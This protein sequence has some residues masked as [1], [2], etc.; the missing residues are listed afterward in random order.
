LLDKVFTNVLAD[1]YSF[2]FFV[3][4]I[5][6]T[7]FKLIVLGSFDGFGLP[8]L[9]MDLIS[10]MIEGNAVSKNL[11][12]YKSKAEHQNRRLFF[13]KPNHKLLTPIHLHTWAQ[14]IIVYYNTP[15]SHIT[16]TLTDSPING[17][18]MQ[19][20]Y[21]NLNTFSLLNNSQVITILTTKNCQ[22]ILSNRKAYRK[23]PTKLRGKNKDKTRTKK[24]EMD[25]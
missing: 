9:P 21:F 13:I 2:T 23:R 1:Q 11:S 25:L 19:I 10:N 5:F 24:Q 3:F 7:L 14:E 8:A 17:I 12:G 6:S 22:T 15:Y 16:R 4:G 18:N 20:K